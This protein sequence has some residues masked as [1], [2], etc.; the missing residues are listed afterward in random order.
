LRPIESY[1]RY[2]NLEA[3]ERKVQEAYR[4]LR[5]FRKNS[6]KITIGEELEVLE[7]RFAVVQE[8][9]RF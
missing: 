4:D 6:P 2:G 1:S 3:G 8:S 9:Y 7:A 5:S